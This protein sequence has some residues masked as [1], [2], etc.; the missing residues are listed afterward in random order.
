MNIAPTSEIAYRIGLLRALGTDDAAAAEAAARST[1]ENGIDDRMFAF[2]GAVEYLLRAAIANDTV[3]TE[4]AWLN[5]RVPGLMD[6]DA[7]TVPAM[8][9]KAQ[10]IA[11]DAWYVSLPREETRRRL[12]VLLD[13][14]RELGFDPT[15]DPMTHVRILAVRGEIQEAIRVALDDVFS[16]SV[17]T[18]LGWKE[19]FS[20][21]LYAD[22]VA[23]PRVQL[24]MRHWEEE[25]AAIRGNVAAY[26][27]DL[28]GAS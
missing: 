15:E 26:L 22:I 11:L 18:N 14:G 8:F 21:P 10:G 13:A 19:A 3:D 7:E 5:E 25:E 28:K 24:A 20:Q 17:A 16:R 2:G 6:V 12:D 9:R 1:I 27:Q 23:D 4:L